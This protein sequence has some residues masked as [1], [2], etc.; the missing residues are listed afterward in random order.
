MWECFK[1]EGIKLKVGS[2]QYVHEPKENTSI[3]EKAELEAQINKL[4]ADYENRWKPHFFELKVLPISEIKNN[5]PY[6][7]QKGG[8]IQLFL[9]GDS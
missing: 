2:L 4:I 8:R 7:L 6:N 5:L 9:T 1:C 3:K